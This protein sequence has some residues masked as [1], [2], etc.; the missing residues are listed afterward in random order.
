MNTELIEII[1][2]E[3][4]ALKHL[5]SLLQK[6]YEYI[7]KKDVFSLEEIVEDIKEG[8]KLVAQNEVERRKLVGKENMNLLVFESKDKELEEAFRDIKKV[9]REIQYQKE[10]NDML[11]KQEISFNTQILSIISPR[12]EVKTYTSLGNLSR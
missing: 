12:R 10:T 11:L 1:R 2:N 3:N 8:N 9:I 5:L 6:Q 7:M 4:K